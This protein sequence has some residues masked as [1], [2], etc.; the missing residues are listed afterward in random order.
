MAERPPARRFQAVP[1]EETVKK[2]RR[3]APEPV[4]TTTR[5]KA[6]SGQAI[7]GTSV[8]KTASAGKR[9][10][11]PTPVETT[12]KS[13]RLDVGKPLSTSKPSPTSVRRSPPPSDTPKL[14]RRFTPDL[15]ETTKRSK[16]A[17]DVRPATLPTDKVRLEPSYFHWHKLIIIFFIRPISLQECQTYIHNQ[18]YERNCPP[19]IPKIPSTP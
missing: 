5:S 18:Q 10:F 3:F 7:N 1:L 12:F 4:E 16:R 19:P 2:S 11:V 13:S 15:I 6:S 17:G 14:R 9:R 8:E